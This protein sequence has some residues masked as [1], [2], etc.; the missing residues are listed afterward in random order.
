MPQN[1]IPFI[2]FG[3]PTFATVILD[4]LQAKG[5]LPSC[6]ITTPDKPQGRTLQ[7]TPS[8][9]K[10]WAL[11]HNIKVLQPETITDEVIEAI[12]KESPLVGIV[13]AYGKI[14]PEPLLD[15]FPKGI[16]N[17]HPS[18]LPKY[19]GSSPVEAALIAGDTT[20][21]VSI[22][23]L[24]S[25]MDHGPILAQE[26]VAIKPNSKAPELETVLAHHGGVLLAK[27]LA[28]WI[29]NECSAT[30]QDDTRATY[31]K[32]ISKHNGDIS[33]IHNEEAKYRHF[34]A[35]Y[36]WPGSYFIHPKAGRVKITDAEMVNGVFIIKKVIPEGKREMS[37]DAFQKGYAN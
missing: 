32:K 35:Y 34:C 29:H 15:L 11:S 37:Y 17:V 7:L 8:P 19:R 3:T 27:M 23:L 31:T 5:F 36:G 26:E 4:E 24:D 10:V 12:K 25:R 33:T 16:L 30:P 1:N 14:L 18:L 28:L 21:G 2:F 9:V 20:T 6:I 13:A 22:M